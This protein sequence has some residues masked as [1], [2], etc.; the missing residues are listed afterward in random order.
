MP[1]R[2]RV[3]AQG[4]E[5][6]RKRHVQPFRHPSDKVPVPAEDALHIGSSV[7][8]HHVATRDALLSA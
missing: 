1:S 6:H 3:P 7:E 4:V 2:S 8:I 5:W